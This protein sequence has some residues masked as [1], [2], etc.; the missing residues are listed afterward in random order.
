MKKLIT[1]VFIFC[2][3]TI[4]F[5]QE[6]KHTITMDRGFFSTDFT[7]DGRE[8]NVNE[9][10]NMLLTVSEAHDKWVLGNVFRY[11]SWGTAGVGGFFVG[12]GAVQSQSFDEDTVNGYKR[13]MALGGV[14]VVAALIVKYI[15]NSKKDSAIELYNE[16]N[17]KI[18]SNGSFSFGIIPTEKGGIALALNF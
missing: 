7:V 1:I 17:G 12:Y 5:A 8:S 10:E 3:S 9:V 18:I 15:G 16:L 6:G 11:I 13:T 14:I 2:L 4:S